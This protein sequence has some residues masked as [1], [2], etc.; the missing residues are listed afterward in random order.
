MKRTH[1]HITGRVQGVFFRAETMRAALDLNGRTWEAEKEFRKQ[2][3]PWFAWYP[4]T[5]GIENGREVKAW[6]QWV[7][8]SQEY[9]LGLEDDGWAS[10]YRIAG[11]CQ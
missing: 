7:E 6:L 3:R 1:V 8:R 5:V 10:Q 9:S 2:W 11:G 4:V